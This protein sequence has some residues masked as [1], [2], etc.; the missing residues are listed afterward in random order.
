MRMEE[1]VFNFSTV[2]GKPCRFSIVGFIPATILVTTA[3][4]SSAAQKSFIAPSAGLP[5]FFD[6]ALSVWV[7]A[8]QS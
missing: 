5:Y 2:S 1:I 7:D 4:C 3:A 8:L 6:A